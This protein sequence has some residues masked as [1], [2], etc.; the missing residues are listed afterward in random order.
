MEGIWSVN[1]DDVVRKKERTGSLGCL[2]VGPECLN[3]DLKCFGLWLRG[4]HS[5]FCTFFFCRGATCIRFCL[6]KD[7]LRDN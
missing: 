6:F 3:E 4:K 1:T 7:L 5:T 2:L